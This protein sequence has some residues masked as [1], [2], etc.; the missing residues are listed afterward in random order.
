MA[1]LMF[2]RRMLERKLEKAVRLQS[3]IQ[4]LPGELL[5]HVFFCG[6]HYCDPEDTILL[7]TLML[8][9]KEW[10]EVATNT[11]ALWSQIVIENPASLAKARFKLQRSKEIPLDI[12]IQFSPQ[13][14]HAQVVTETVLHAMDILKPAIWRWRSFRLAVPS[15]SQAQVALSQC[16]QP[17]PLLEVLSV[18]IHQFMQEDTQRFSQP[19]TGAIFQGHLPSLRSCSFT[20]FNFGWDV[21][22]VSHLRVLRLGGYWNGFAPSVSTII[23][24][25]RACPGLEELALRNMSDVEGAAGGCSSSDFHRQFDR[26]GDFDMGAASYAGPSYSPKS[27]EIVTMPRLRRASFYY[28]G[29]ERMHALMSQL[30]LPA[31]ERLEFAYLDN[32][33]PILKYLKHQP[34]PLAHMRIESCF[35]NELKLLSLLERFSSLRTLEF[36]DVEDI[37]A[38]F[39]SVSPIRFDGLQQT[40]FH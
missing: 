39:L 31:L 38:N 6:V 5:G 27:S 21:G 40:G 20:S 29:V 33:T 34:M 4:R 12:S 37:S 10:A 18:Q 2:E 32:L 23:S 22:L 25:L 15:R 17:A 9:C 30:A 7:S 26:K 16:K 13:F 14:E 3:P 1:N 19:P 8:V 24:I 35:F 36:V 11:P 28:S